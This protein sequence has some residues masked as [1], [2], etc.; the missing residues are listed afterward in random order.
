MDQPDA[1]VG[2]G[3]PF[4]L[5]DIAEQPGTYFNPRTEVTVIVDDSGSI[6]QTV[7]PAAVEGADWFRV[8]DEPA[9]DEQFRDELLEG[10]E[11]GLRSGRDGAIDAVTLEPDEDDFDPDGIDDLDEDDRFDPD[12]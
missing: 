2:R 4:E 8:S 5:E 6:D 1:S 11:G 10:F 3:T 7:L 9:I 12:D